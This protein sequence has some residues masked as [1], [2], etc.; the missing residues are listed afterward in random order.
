MKA[1]AEALLQVERSISREKGPFSL[2]ALF[3]REEAP[4]KWA[5]TLLTQM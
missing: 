3:L 2:F 5:L 4:G 1:P